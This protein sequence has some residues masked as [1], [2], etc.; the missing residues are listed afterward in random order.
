MTPR[1]AI[2]TCPLCEANCGLKVELEGE[3]IRSIRGD[4]ED[5]FSRGHLCPKAT[6]LGDLMDDPDRVRHPLKKRGESWVE[7]PWDEALDEAG[8][9]LAAIQ[10]AHGKNAVGLYFGNPLA[11]NY[12]ASLALPLVIASLKTRN[13]F[14]ANSVDGLARFYASRLLYG[15]G[16]VLPVPDVDRTHFMLVFGATPAVSNGSLMTAPGMRQRLKDLRAR[17]GKLVV[18]DPRLTETA[19]LADAHHFIRPGTDVFMLAA[20]LQVIFEERLADPSALALR[21]CTGLD[22]LHATLAPFTPELAQRECGVDAEALRALARAFAT[23]KRAVC[24]GRLGISLQVHGALCNWLIDVL[25]IVTGNF[26]RDGGAMFP[27]PSIDLAKQAVRL[28][29]DGRHGRWSS[30]VRGLQEFNGEL[31]AVA[32]AEEIDTPGEGQVRGF[33]CLAGNPVLSVPDGRRLDRALAGLEFM[34]SVDLYVNETSR[35]ADLI[36]PPSFGLE[37][38]HFPLLFQALSVRNWLRHTPGLVTPPPG[39]R[40]E[41]QLFAEL[42]GSVVRHRSLAGRAIGRGIAALGRR[43]SPQTVVDLLLRTGPRKLRL[44]DVSA[45][46][47]GLDFGPMEPRLPAMLYRDDGK[48]ALA[49]QPFLDAL[50]GLRG[51]EGSHIEGS[52]APSLTLIGRRGLRSDNSWL[53][54]VPRLNRGKADCTL[55]IHPQDLTAQGLDGATEAWL[56]SGVGRTLVTLE[57]TDAMRPGVV[58][59]PHGWGHARDGLRLQVAAKRP[60]ASANDV[61]STREIDPLSGTAAVNGGAVWLE[62]QG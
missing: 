29:A 36:L 14:S 58:S 31:P 27:S 42:A 60:G 22:E 4:D 40:S 7:V 11:H 47:H 2:A 43:G 48:I 6:A 37:H 44:K 24:Y 35:H 57:S 5:P 19:R 41:W 3:S 62:A 26:D 18:V 1:T 20:L 16:L 8:S 53:H 25:N 30:R 32:L 33:V 46:P 39:V 50:R 9:R 61:I 59:L 15:N 56:C 10:N 28:K 55:Q 52:A 34:V 17:G 49:P 13:L 54:N 12:G 21:F 45:A 38:D 51:V 23:A